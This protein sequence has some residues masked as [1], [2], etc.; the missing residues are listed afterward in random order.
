[1]NLIQRLW[2]RFMSLFSKEKW[3]YVKMFAID[4]VTF[5][6]KQGKVF[7]HLFESDRGNRRIKSSSSFPLLGQKTLEEFVAS[8]DIYQEKL[9][10]WE[11]GRYDPEIPRFSDIG[12]DDTANALRGTIK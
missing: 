7:I 2:N 10:R 12:E 1:M 11:N 4:N 6:R 9:V 5:E 3:A 8:Q